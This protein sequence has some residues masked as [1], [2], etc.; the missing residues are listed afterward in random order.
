ML[1]GIQEKDFHKIPFEVKQELLPMPEIYEK[2]F[3]SYNEKTLHVKD[4]EARI[5]LAKKSVTKANEAYE[6]NPEKKEELLKEF[7]HLPDTIAKLQSEL[8]DLERELTPLEYFYLY[9]KAISSF[10]ETIPKKLDTIKPSDLEK[11][12][13]LWFRLNA[14]MS[15]LTFAYTVTDAANPTSRI[16][17]PDDV[18]TVKADKDGTPIQSTD[19][20]ITTK[21]VQRGIS[22]ILMQ[23]R[24][25]EYSF[26]GDKE[27]KKL[28][29]MKPQTFGTLGYRNFST[30]KDK[31]LGYL[32]VGEKDITKKG[33]EELTFMQVEQ[34]FFDKIKEANKTKNVVNLK[35]GFFEEE[36]RYNPYPVEEALKDIDVFIKADM[37]NDAIEKLCNINRAFE[38]KRFV[39]D[40]HYYTVSIGGVKI[41]PVDSPLK[42]YVGNSQVGDIFKEPTYK[43]RQWVEQAVKG[44]RAIFASRTIN[45]EHPSE[46][47]YHLWEMP[48]VQYS[49]TVKRQRA[50]VTT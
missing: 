4:L 44:I 41:I 43:E 30:L 10:T 27:K 2:G 17:Y 7:G 1:I 46:Y 9:Y 3:H 28:A 33:K 14:D 5:S 42:Y 34:M 32:T 49:V 38:P 15:K 11:K 19:S 35:Y 22:Y 25:V 48:G 8:S 24:E 18:I 40:P 13:F 50:E 12:G 37:L 20:A 16:I 47:N 39:I 6:E 36:Y 26:I 45:V 21:L 31:H 29:G 23:E